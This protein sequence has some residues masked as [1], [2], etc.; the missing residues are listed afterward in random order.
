MKEL[1]RQSI[2]RAIRRLYP[3]HA[4][5]V[6]AVDYAP[7]EANADIASNAALVLAKKFN[8]KPLE[9]ADRLRETLSEVEGKIEISVAS[10]GFLNFKVADISYWHGVLAKI[11]E[12]GNQFGQSDIGK[13]K[14]INVESVSA[15]PTGP[16]TV[17][18]G[19][20]AVIGLIVSNVLKSRGYDVVRDYYYNDAGL[21]MKRLG[22]SVKIR[23][24]EELGEKTEFPEQID[25][26]MGTY[27]RGI[28]VQF[29]DK[30]KPQTADDATIEEY[31]D[32]AAQIIFSDIKQTLK[33]LG[34][35]FD[36]FVKESDQDIERILKDLEAAGTV[37]EKDGAKWLKTGREEDRVLVRSTGEPTY[38]LADIAYHVNKLKQGYD[39]I[40]NILGADHIAQFPDI[41]HAVEAFG[42]DSSKIEVIINQFVTLAGGKKMST[43]KAHYVTLDEL[44]EEVGEAVTLFFLASVAPSTH[45]TFDLDLAKDTSHKNP[46][47]KIQYAHTRISSIIRKSGFDIS[48]LTKEDVSRIRGSR[49]IELVKEAAKYPEILKEISQS[50]SVHLLPHYLLRVADKL[51]SFYETKEGRVLQ[52]DNYATRASLALVR[53]LMIVLANGLKILGIEAP[54]E[55]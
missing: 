27:I 53:A 42:Y 36:N 6:F 9:V 21:Q 44:M 1:I 11:L 54:E 32:F 24:Q 49:G 31:S 35:T 38:R 10:P 37:Y 19:R 51:N 17:G 50:Y 4:D 3:D 22:E 30:N 29:I 12:E 45:M 48:S 8:K 41:Q 46:V 47:Y 43:R 26:Y 40:I 20:G 55:M 23:V 14:K 15:N 16:L 33:R 5:I 28:A 52:K 18:H 25:I 2:Q 34:V 13:G 7:E 39:R